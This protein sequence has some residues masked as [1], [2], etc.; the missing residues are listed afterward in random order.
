MAKNNIYDIVISELILKDGSGGSGSSAPYL[1]LSSTI[2][3]NEVQA[4]YNNPSV[5]FTSLVSNI[6][7]GYSITANSHVITYPTVEPNTVGS[8]ASLSGNATS[9]IL[10]IVGNTFTVSSTVVLEHLTLPDITLNATLVITAVLPIYYGIKAYSG[11]PDT[12]GLSQMASSDINFIMTTSIVGRLYVVLP[13][14]SDPLISITDF[15]GMTITVAD[16][17]TPITSGSFV[18]YI[19]DYDT[20]L[21][22]SDEKEFTLNYS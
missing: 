21:V 22:G 2:G 17:F 18:Y 7:S 8:T 5:V 4:L 19:L 6:P 16:D 1:T 10:G 9:V 13:T 14:A 3:S 12:T 11:T 15:N 20:Q